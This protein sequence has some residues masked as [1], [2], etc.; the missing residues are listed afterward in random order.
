MKCSP[1]SKSTPDTRTL[2][3][4]E[5]YPYCHNPSHTRVSLSESVI[6]AGFP[7]PAGEFTENAI[8]LNEHMVKHPAATF[9]IRVSG[10]SMTGAGIFPGDLLV[11]D[12]SLEAVHHSIVIAIIDGEFTV[13]RL[14][15]QTGQGIVL[16]PENPQFKEI[17]IS[18]ETD[19]EIWGVV[20]HVI[21]DTKQ[22]RE[23]SYP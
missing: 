7:S 17:R 19:F 2:T 23:N 14:S 18:P 16:L 8:D 6:C 1:I 15:K 4:V 3:E 20:T 11:V 21:H 5:F 10:V 22:S 12:R 13:K 9:F